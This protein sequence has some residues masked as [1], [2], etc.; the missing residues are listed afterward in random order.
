MS[1]EGTY[2]GTMKHG[3]GK[4]R[5]SGSTYEGEFRDDLKSGSGVLTWDDGRQYRG[6]F[7]NG[8]FH[9]Q[10]VMTWP[11][12]RRYR[13]QYA[14]DRKHGEGTFAWAD[15]RRYQGQWVV[16]KR[17]GVGVYTNAK[18]FT[19]TGTWQLDR[20]IR[21]EAVDAND[22]MGQTLAAK[23][24]ASM[25]ARK[26]AEDD[27]AEE[28]VPAPQVTQEEPAPRPDGI[29]EPSAADDCETKERRTVAM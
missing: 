24:Y 3:Y 28:V 7:E 26:S 1:Y 2:L 29:Q 12:G 5:M 23:A 10:A 22:P 27:P 8:V 16:G 13:G 18:G 20:P 21:W 6:Q 15:G 19:R 14:D 4:L 11:D 17:H 9:G 25:S